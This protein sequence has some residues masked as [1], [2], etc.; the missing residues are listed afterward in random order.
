MGN[1]V[2]HVVCW[3]LMLVLPLQALAGM[4]RLYDPHSDWHPVHAAHPAPHAHVDRAQPTV[5]TPSSVLTSESA[6]VQ[7]ACADSAALAHPACQWVTAE[8]SDR[9]SLPPACNTCALCC[10]LLIPATLNLL[11]PAGV[12]ISPPDRE[13]RFR[14]VSPH[15]LERPPRPL[16]AA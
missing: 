10:L 14:S 8:S 16:I 15:A 11:A 3:C 2:R 7:T 1:T 5:G 13:A 4:I 9:S 12:S 6:A